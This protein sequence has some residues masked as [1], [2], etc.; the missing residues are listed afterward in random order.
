MVNGFFSCGSTH[1]SSIQIGLCFISCCSCC[2][3]YFSFVLLVLVVVL[4][5]VIV[6]VLFVLVRSYVHLVELDRIKEIFTNWW[7]WFRTP[8]PY[9]T[10]P[11][12]NKPSIRPYFWEGY[13]GGVG[14]LAFKQTMISQDV[15][16]TQ[17]LIWLPF[18]WGVNVGTNIYKGGL[19]KVT[20]ILGI[21]GFSCRSC[22]VFLATIVE[23]QVTPKT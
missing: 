22:V 19:E 21:H 5:L 4:V 8:L 1:R 14:W 17:E 12:D 18:S 16:S 2:S 10:K 23:L 3:S 6:F 15:F 20:L 7:F 13:V 9:R 11:M